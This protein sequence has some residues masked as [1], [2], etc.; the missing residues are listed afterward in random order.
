MAT[1]FTSLAYLNPNGLNSS[2][3]LRMKLADSYSFHATLGSIRDMTKTSPNSCLI[4]W[5][6]FKTLVVRDCLF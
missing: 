2:P 5:F 4:G 3:D 1:A 6:S